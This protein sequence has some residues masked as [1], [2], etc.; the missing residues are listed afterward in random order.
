MF[1]LSPIV[2]DGP[3]LH[4]RAGR[5]GILLPVNVAANLAASVESAAVPQ[6]SATLF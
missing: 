4:C 5:R 1:L 2:D 6:A 3:V